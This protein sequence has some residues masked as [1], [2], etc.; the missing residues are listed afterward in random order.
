MLKTILIAALAPLL[1]AN[2]AQSQK[3]DALASGL[4]VRITVDTGQRITGTLARLSADSVFLSSGDGKGN[5]LALSRNEVLSM[6]AS[7]GK[8]RLVGALAGTAVGVLL[9]GIAGAIIWSNQPD[10]TYGDET[11]SV[12]SIFG[13]GC[14]STTER[15]CQK[16]CVRVGAALRAIGTAALGIPIGAITGAVIGS[17]KWTVLH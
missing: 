8:N 6:E 13:G 15:V 7:A 17:E 11:V 9:G 12:C 4:R 10:P 5:T 16:D 14:H 3:T 2:V 1:V